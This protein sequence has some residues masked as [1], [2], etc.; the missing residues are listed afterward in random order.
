MAEQEYLMGDEAMGRGAVE[1]GVK[2]EKE[3]KS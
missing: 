2:V 1:A 3:I